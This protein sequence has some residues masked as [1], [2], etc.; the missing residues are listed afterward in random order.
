MHGW[1]SP[2]R[3]VS[4]MNAIFFG[5][6]NLCDVHMR[7]AMTFAVPRGYLRGPP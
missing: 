6:F 1:K 4:D 3:M 7:I 5:I 2:T